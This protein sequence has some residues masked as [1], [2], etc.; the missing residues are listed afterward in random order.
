M[1]RSVFALPFRLLSFVNVCM[2]LG[3]AQVVM[4][5]IAVSQN[6]LLLDCIGFK[7][8]LTAHVTSLA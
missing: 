8:E 2:I 4:K 6:V 3:L 1:N 5:T 7:R